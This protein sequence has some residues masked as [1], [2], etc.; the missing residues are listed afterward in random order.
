MIPTTT[1]TPAVYDDKW[2]LNNKISDNDGTGNKTNV[3]FLENGSQ[4]GWSAGIND[5]L[6]IIGE[7]DQG[8]T[9]LYKGAAHIFKTNN[10]S[11]IDTISD[12]YPNN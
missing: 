12:G 4:F 5:S 9:G 10:L 2:V 1:C 3:D 7:Y 11:H 6:L 8:G